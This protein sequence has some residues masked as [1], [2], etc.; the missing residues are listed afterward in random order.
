MI[1]D[2]DPEGKAVEKIATTLPVCMN[3]LGPQS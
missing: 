1:Y 3:S 2:N